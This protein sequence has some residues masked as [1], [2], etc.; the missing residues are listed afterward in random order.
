MI[1]RS[2]V[3]RFRRMGMGGVEDVDIFTGVE[4]VVQSWC[5]DGDSQVRRGNCEGGGIHLIVLDV[6]C[7]PPSVPDD[8]QD[9]YR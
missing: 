1:V 5:L 3:G 7:V 2:Q 6:S 9:Q 4:G 8:L